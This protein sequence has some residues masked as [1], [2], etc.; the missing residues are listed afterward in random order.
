MDIGL[1]QILAVFVTAIKSIWALYWEF[2]SS[3]WIL[4]NVSETQ[5]YTI[6]FCEIIL[7]AV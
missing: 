6:F 4:L 1:F 7:A 3:M 2:S 5:M